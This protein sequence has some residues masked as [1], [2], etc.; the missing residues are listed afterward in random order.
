M[1]N[2]D[3]ALPFKFFLTFEVS[4]TRQAWYF[5]LANGVL[6]DTK[7]TTCFLVFLKN[8]KNVEVDWDFVIFSRHFEFFICISQE[9]FVRLTQFFYV[10]SV[11][12]YS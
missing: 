1:P 8:A 9:R 4:L 7:L 3:K 2:F 11:I 12:I 5:F 6:E 10:I